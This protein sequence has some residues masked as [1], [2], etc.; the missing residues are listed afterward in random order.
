MADDHGVL[1]VEDEAE[2]RAM[3]AEYLESRGYRVRE[4]ETAREPRKSAT[5]KPELH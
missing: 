1:V 5:A 4:A 2:V 3:L